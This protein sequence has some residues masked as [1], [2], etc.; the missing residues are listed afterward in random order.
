MVPAAR[1]YHYPS[2]T[3]AIANHDVGFIQQAT[4][5]NTALR[6]FGFEALRTQDS[7]ARR[8]FDTSAEMSET[9]TCRFSPGPAHITRA[10]FFEIPNL[11]IVQMDKF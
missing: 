10:P 7:S 4:I 1:L 3:L 11:Y 5:S 2:L 8:H 9:P 6:S